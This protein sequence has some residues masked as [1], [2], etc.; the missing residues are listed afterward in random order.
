M[1]RLLCLMCVL[2][3]LTGCA[4]AGQEPSR[5]NIVATT[6]PTYL[7]ALAVTQGVEGVS[8][9]RLDTGSV[10]C[11]HDYTLTVNDMKKLSQADVIV[12]NGAGLED[13]M[14][15]TLAATD[16]L[17]IDCSERVE[18]LP[19]VSHHDHEHDGEHGHF[20]P[21]YWMDPLNFHTMVGNVRRGL[22]DLFPGEVA[23]D[24]SANTTLAFEQLQPLYELGLKYLYPQSENAIS[25]PGLITFHDGFQYLAYTFHLPLLASIEEEAGSEASAKEMDEIIR[26]V[27]EKNVPVIFTEVNGSDA[28]AKAIARETGCAV[29]QLSMIMDGW[30]P[31][32][33]DSSPITPYTELMLNNIYTLINGFAGRE[34]LS[35]S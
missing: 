31:T 32:E 8:V 11:L 35:P 12:M 30:E 29:A 26:L 5:L 18:L 21:H 34:V 27:K 7:A 14:S 17:V 9:S 25:V 24:L 4:P 13:F 33:E 19:V 10:S 23:P 15:D 20:D 3:L 22:W 2:A 16:A 6:Y 1:K 28:T